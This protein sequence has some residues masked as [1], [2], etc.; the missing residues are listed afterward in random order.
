VQ[1]SLN[2]AV[3][4]FHVFRSRVSCARSQLTCNPLPLDPCLLLL[5][6]Q[7]GR[8]ALHSCAVAGRA[9]TAAIL[10][11][12]KAERDARDSEGNTPLILAARYGQLDVVRVLAAAGADLRAVN[13]AGHTA[14]DAARHAKSAATA[15]LLVEAELDAEERADRAARGAPPKPAGMPAKPAAAPAAAAAAGGG[16][17]AAVGRPVVGKP[18]GP[19][20]DRK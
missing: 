19:K 15:E 10:L 7:H 13:S 9:S 6:P 20:P 3:V 4:R 2:A 16:A 5:P 14:S 12:G 1:P 8:T 18:A 11:S 17:A